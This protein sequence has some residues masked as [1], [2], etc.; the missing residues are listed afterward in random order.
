MLHLY[1]AQQKY[2]HFDELVV[3]LPMFSPWV[4]N[5]YIAVSRIEA[6]YDS[7]GMEKQTDYDSLQT[8]SII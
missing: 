3:S 8:N 7:V 2:R 6:V 5:I 4:V 1:Y